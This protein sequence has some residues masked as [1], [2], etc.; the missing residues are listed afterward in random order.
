MNHK[1]TFYITT[2]IYY[3]SAK[4][5][6]GHAYC[7]TIADAYARFNRLRGKDVFFLTGSDEHGQKIQ[8]IA[9]A[10]GMNPKEY[11]DQIVASFKALWERLNISYDD[12]IRT[13]DKHHEVLVQKIFQIL[14]E[15]SDIYKSTY[16]GLYCTPC[17][18][19]WLER[20]TND[21]KCPDCGR[22][23]EE[24]EEESYFFR[25]SKYAEPLLNYYKEH[26]EFL[27]PAARLKEMESFIKSG[28]ED[29]CVSRTAVTWGISVPFDPKHSIYV[30]FD[31]VVN[32]IS[33]L[34]YLTNDDT[35][36]KKYWPADL[37]LVGKEIMRFHTIIW[38]AMLLALD[39]PLPKTV[40]GHGWLVIEGEKMSKSKGNVVDPNLLIDEFGADAIRYFLL[41]E[42]TL[43]SDGNFSRDSLIR[44]INADLA[45]DLG[46]LIHRTSSMYE[47]YFPEAIPELG[48]EEEPEKELAELA[49]KA[50]A[51]FETLIDSYEPQNA[52][53]SL[54]VL[55]RRANKYLD[56]TAPWTLAKNKDY[57]RL[58]RVL[59]TVG[60]VLR[61]ASVALTP[62]L[63]TSAAKIRAQLGLS[64]DCTWEEAKVWNGLPVGN[65][66]LKAEPLFPRIEEDEKE[67]GPVKPTKE[68]KSTKAEAT[69]KPE[70]TV[71]TEEQIEFDD[72]LKVHLKVATILTA[73]RIKGSDKLLRLE[74]DLGTEKRQIVAGIG[75][76][77]SPEELIGKQ[78]AVVTNLKP[79]K[80]MGL[81]SQAMIIA[82]GDGSTLAVFNPEKPVKA[83][84]IIG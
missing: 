48:A 58:A 29:L 53:E 50:L 14:Y 30:W 31:A 66:I 68:V 23:V 22:P 56:S 83:G 25:L 36:Y 64:A 59:Y 2:P 52:L 46:N 41:R 17:E 74:A 47:K 42:I 57:P 20:Q 51:E 71:V 81:E 49:K 79:R 39:L 44:R 61:I 82:A 5:H 43:G 26:P 9:E 18:A 19:F 33:A 6:I 45:N 37:H 65:R 72:F 73:E 7:T 38:P 70:A 28:L 35:L 34:G 78:V 54:W 10:Q 12:F 55:I 8:R 75:K 76:A 21:G 11:V 32:Y 67:E 4:L 80:I 27:Q 3:P 40:F 16:K 77:Y 60:E 62:I 15:K 24:V 63:P 84:S 69:K 1:E 13:T